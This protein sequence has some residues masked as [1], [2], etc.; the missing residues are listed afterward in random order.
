MGN[1]GCVVEGCEYSSGSVES[2]EAHISGSTRGEHSGLLGRNH[3]EALVEEAEATSEAGRNLAVGLGEAGESG[4]SSGAKFPASTAL[5]VAT[6]V[7]VV[8][9]VVEGDGGGVEEEIVQPEQG[10]GIA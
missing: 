5:V 10:G 2:V 1:I 9:A 4:G 8:S 3:R 6:L 7:L